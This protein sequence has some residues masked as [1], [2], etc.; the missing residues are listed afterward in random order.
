MFPKSYEKDFFKISTKMEPTLEISYYASI[1]F[2]SKL[3]K[4]NQLYVEEMEP[5]LH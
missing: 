5:G 3:G 2:Q 4:E 1:P